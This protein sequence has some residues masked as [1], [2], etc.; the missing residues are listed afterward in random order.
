MY[1][2]IERNDVMAGQSVFGNVDRCLVS[3]VEEARSPVEAFRC[4]RP[5]DSGFRESFIAFY[6]LRFA[7]FTHADALT[8]VDVLS[9]H[10][11]WLG[12]QLHIFIRDLWKIFFIFYESFFR[13]MTEKDRIGPP[14]NVPGPVLLI[15]R[16]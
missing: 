13:I 15:S 9:V 2:A 12:D 7:V 3:F 10:V 16:K 6:K 5:V 14:G 1:F 4:H 11:N 8:V